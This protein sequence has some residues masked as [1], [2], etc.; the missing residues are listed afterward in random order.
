MTY[1]P[2]T[3]C[4]A[5]G[6]TDLEPYFDLGDQPLANSFHRGGS[7]QPTY[8]LAVNV[9]RRCWHTQL[10]VAVEPD[11]LFKNYLYTSGTT[12]TLQKYFQ[13]FAWS[14]TQGKRLRVLDIAS[15]DGS[16][17]E[18]F[19]VYECEVQGVDP[20]ENL[21][22]LSEVKGVPTHVGY[23]N[24]DTFNQIGG[25]WD[26]IIAMNVL[27]HVPNPAEF[28][29]LCRRA[30]APDGTI[31]VQ[32]SQALMLKNGEFDTI[33]HEHHSFFTCNS[34]Q[35]LAARVG[36][37]AVDI[38]H[39]P[40]HGTSYLMKLRH[41]PA[42]T[43]FSVTLK[44][45]YDMGYYDMKTYREFAKRADIT[46]EK[47]HAIVNGFAAASFGIVGYGAAAKGMTF[48]NYANLAL[49]C[50]IDDNPMKVGLYAPGSNTPIAGPEMLEESGETLFVILAWNFYE[51]IVDRIKMIRSNPYDSFLT[52]F[53][54]VKLIG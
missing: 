45:E 13:T 9:C 43:S 34:F 39:V 6:S 50:I 28:L 7:P 12:N 40:V 32:T 14:V 29:A 37:Y 1:K 53:P 20:A 22:P 23:W 24:E 38:R 52:Y 47:V 25:D 16:L 18:E 46:R 11:L 17:L 3:E 30:L 33:Y 41:Q 19:R 26:V 54:Q 27:A 2:L 42:R 51:E 8:P 21:R 5:C 44:H 31:Y 48:L 35:E 4:L 49:D 36:L 10:T 15:N